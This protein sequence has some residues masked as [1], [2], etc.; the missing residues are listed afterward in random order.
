MVGVGGNRTGTDAELTR[1]V[2]AAKLRTLSHKDQDQDQDQ[3]R[4]HIDGTAAA[5]MFGAA[6]ENW[7]DIC[8]KGGRLCEAEASLTRRLKHMPEL[9]TGRKT[10]VLLLPEMRTTLTPRSPT[11][12]PQ[13]SSAAASPRRHRAAG[14]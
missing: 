6:L 7:A 11:H 8:P 10:G 13:S 14:R 2:L 5:E 3:D 12:Q 9:G 1:Q 4:D